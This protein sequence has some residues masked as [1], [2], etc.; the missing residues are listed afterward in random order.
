MEHEIWIFRA[1]NH[2]KSAQ[3]VLETSEIDSWEFFTSKLHFK[4]KN[5]KKKIEMFFEKK[6]RISKIQNFGKIYIIFF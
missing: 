1:Q 3:I 4:K 2:G 5:L 6:M